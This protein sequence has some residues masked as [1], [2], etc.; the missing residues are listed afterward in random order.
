MFAWVWIDLVYRYIHFTII[1]GKKQR[2]VLAFLY[3]SLMFALLFSQKEDIFSRNVC[4]FRSTETAG[5]GY[6]FT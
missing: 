4:N 2:N 6:F 5:D 1:R 3:T